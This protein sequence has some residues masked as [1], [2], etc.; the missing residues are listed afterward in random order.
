MIKQRANRRYWALLPLGFVTA[1]G[2]IFFLNIELAWPQ[3]L[4]S[5]SEPDT[6]FP[7][8]DGLGEQAKPRPLSSP[9]GGGDGHG[10]EG[11]RYGQQLPPIKD[12]DEFDRFVKF[13][14]QEICCSGQH[15]PPPPP[16]SGTEI[17]QRD[18]VPT[19]SED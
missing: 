2:V 13:R 14:R 5:A 16:K 19:S 15:V 6:L 7:T 10:F 1:L 9:D 12:L 3:S 18:Q 8:Y 17:F 11:S 4:Q